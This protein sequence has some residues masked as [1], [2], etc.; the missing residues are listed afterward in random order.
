MQRGLETQPSLSDVVCF[1]RDKLA[2]LFKGKGHHGNVSAVAML[3]V[4][5]LEPTVKKIS[6]L[7]AD[8][9]VEFRA[10][11]HQ[12]QKQA[13]DAERKAALNSEDPVDIPPLECSEPLTAAVPSQG[14]A[15]QEASLL[16]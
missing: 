8:L 16:P 2:K 10:K 4:D 6:Q 14:T 7:A 12:L 9:T 1:R 3:A 15:A 5:S 11:L 13:L